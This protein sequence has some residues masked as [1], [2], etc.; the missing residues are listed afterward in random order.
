MRQSLSE[1][2]I[3]ISST[4]SNR[5]IFYVLCLVRSASGGLIAR[6]KVQPRPLWEHQEVARVVNAGFGWQRQSSIINRRKKISPTFM[7][8]LWRYIL[9]FLLPCIQIPKILRW[10]FAKMVTS[11]N[12]RVR[13]EVHTH[14]KQVPKHP[15]SSSSSLSNLQH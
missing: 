10:N 12:S 1:S 7:R 9:C 15:G 13:I 11:H 3:L 6:K 4:S 8:E 5:L 2:G 14:P